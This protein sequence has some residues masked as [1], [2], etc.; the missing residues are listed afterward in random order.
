MCS[1]LFPLL[2]VFLLLPVAK[3]ARSIATNP[4]ILGHLQVIFGIML[5]CGVHLEI[6]PWARRTVDAW[7]GVFY[8]YF[9]ATGGG[10]AFTMWAD[11]GQ[12]LSKFRAS[13]MAALTHH[14]DAYDAGDLS[15]TDFL[16]AVRLQAHDMMVERHAATAAAAAAAAAAA[17]VH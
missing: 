10:R 16:V 13:V 8:A 4:D 12:G 17:E 9:G 1:S 14:A 6:A 5:A 7:R 2:L 3:S 15:T 11:R